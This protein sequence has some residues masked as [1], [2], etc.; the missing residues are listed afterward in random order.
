M[1]FT[2]QKAG[3]LNIAAFLVF[4]FNV[5]ALVLCYRYFK[6][7]WS[8]E[9]SEQFWVDFNNKVHILLLFFPLVVTTF[10]SFLSSFV[11]RGGIVN[12]K[13]WAFA[14]LISAIY[15]LCAYIIEWDTQTVFFGPAMMLIPALYGLIFLTC[16]FALWLTPGPAYRRR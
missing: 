3:P 9:L 13:C 5:A 12:G 6:T 7:K 1:S 8:I 2:Q 11:E 10:F 4:V 16:F 15:S 14:I